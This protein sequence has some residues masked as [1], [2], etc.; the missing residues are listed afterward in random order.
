MDSSELDPATIAKYAQKPSYSPYANR[1]Y[2]TRAFWGDEHLHTA[3]SADAGMSGATLTPEDAVRF[4][5]GEQVVSNTGQ[6][7]KLSRPLDWL[8]VTDHSDGM[9]TITEI[10]DGNPDLMADPTLRR[11]HGMMLAGPEQAAAATMEAIAAQ[12]NKR[13]PPAIMDP[14]S[15]SPYG[16]RVTRSWRGTTSRAALRR[17]SPMS[18]RQM[19]TAATIYIA[20]SS[21][22]TVTIK[23]IR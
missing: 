9:G 15:R 19:R 18:G 6:A 13:L 20:T 21:I 16:K 10:K 3:W 14:G 17:S 2:P 7:V 23:P 12:S 1:S 5:R 11:W 22:A 8:A 4:A